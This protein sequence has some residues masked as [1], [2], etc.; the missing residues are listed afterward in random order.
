MS[1]AVP[2]GRTPGWCQPQRWVGRLVS[3][4]QGNQCSDDFEPEKISR[5]SQGRSR[6]ISLP[7]NEHIHPEAARRPQDA[8]LERDAVSEGAILEVS[9]S[10]ATVAN[11][12]RELCRARTV[13]GG[14]QVGAKELGLANRDSRLEHLGYRAPVGPC[15]AEVSQKL[16]S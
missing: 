12:I 6:A 2:P 4:A 15:C 10:P 8:K 5:V 11:H 13:P 16:L 3:E 9:D 7:A 1:S 14:P